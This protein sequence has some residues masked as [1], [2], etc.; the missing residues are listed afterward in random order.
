MG[1]EER[2]VVRL[3]ADQLVLLSELVRLGK[4]SSESDAVKDA[5]ATLLKSF[6]TQEDAEKILAVRSAE[7]SL[8]LDDFTSN[9]SPANEILLNVIAKGLESERKDL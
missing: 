8:N 2:I 1:T 6:F 3:S 9:D 5:V 4:Y 7:R